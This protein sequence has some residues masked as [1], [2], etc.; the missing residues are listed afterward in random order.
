MKWTVA[1]PPASQPVDLDEVKAQLRIDSND[2]NEH[3]ALLVDAA[4]DFAE[5]ELA[6]SLVQRRLIATFYVDEPIHLPRGPLIAIVSVIDDDGNA[7]TDYDVSRVGHSDRIALNQTATFPVTVTYDAGYADGSVPASIRLAILAHVGTLYE[8][9]ES[10]V[11]KQKL[12]VPHH[13]EAFYRLKSRTI[14]VG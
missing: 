6:A 10:V 11:D 3:L 14:G 12:A 1:T 4:V 8:N 13:L 7:I 9:R 2:E 5:D